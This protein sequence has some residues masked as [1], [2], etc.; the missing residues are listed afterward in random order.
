MYAFYKCIPLKEYYK[1]SKVY[2]V[3]KISQLF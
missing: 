1:G 2:Y 3:L